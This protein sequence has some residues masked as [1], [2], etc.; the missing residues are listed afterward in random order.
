MKETK[1]RRTIPDEQDQIDGITFDKLGRM[2]YHPDFHTNHRTPFTLDELIY[3]CKFYEID[4]PRTVSFAI[5]R[6]EH[7]IMSKVSDLRKQGQ[8]QIYKNM[9]DDDWIKVAK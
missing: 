8:Y 1:Q 7:T 5:G 2:N 3:M 4:G 9:S 6:T